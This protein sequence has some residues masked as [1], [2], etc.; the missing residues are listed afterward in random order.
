LESEA[1]PEFCPK[2]ILGMDTDGVPLD[3]IDAIGI[4]PEALVL[5][6]T[7]G[8]VLDD[9]SVVVG[10][11]LID[12]ELVFDARPD[13]VDVPVLD[14]RADP[15]PRFDARG[16]GLMELEVVSEPLAVFDPVPGCGLSAGDPTSWVRGKGGKSAP[17]EPVPPPLPDVGLRLLKP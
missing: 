6:D 14:P 1:D 12:D 5:L 8:L 9:K 3:D 2:L 7:V 11:L 15:E 13:N 17:I 16:K 4:P 10:E